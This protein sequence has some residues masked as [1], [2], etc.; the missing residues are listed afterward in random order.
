MVLNAVTQV[1]SNTRFAH[2]GLTGT[3]NITRN[4][5]WA[6]RKVFP[7]IDDGLCKAV[8]AQMLLWLGSL[9]ED[10]RTLI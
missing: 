2:Q 3:T 4:K 8:C 7:V 1:F 9:R 6:Q 10:V 5:K